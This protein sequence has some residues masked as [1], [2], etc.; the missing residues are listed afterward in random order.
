MLVLAVA[1]DF[2]GLRQ[3]GIVGCIDRLEI[4]ERAKDVIVPPRGERETD[5]CW[6]DNLARAVR[7]KEPVGTNGRVS[8]EQPLNRALCCCSQASFRS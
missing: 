5:E 4:I 1:N 7:A 2:D 8:F 6:L 3:E